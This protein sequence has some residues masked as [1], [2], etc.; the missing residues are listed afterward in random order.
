M[1]ASM[2][3]LPARMTLNVPLATLTS[4]IDNS[5]V[6]VDAFHWQDTTMMG[7]AMWLNLALVTA[8]LVSRQEQVVLVV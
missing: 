1:I 5:T 4:P 2:T 3:A 8:Q 7:Q 6:A